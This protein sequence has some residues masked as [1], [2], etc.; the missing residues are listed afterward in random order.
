MVVAALALFAVAAW[1]GNRVTAT[2]E[3]AMALERI[4][5]VAGRV[6]TLEVELERPLLFGFRSCS[7]CDLVSFG[8]VVIFVGSNETWCR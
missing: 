3:L 8:R 2:L 1:V 7:K 6:A 5:A 4:E